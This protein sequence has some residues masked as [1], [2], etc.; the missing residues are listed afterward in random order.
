MINIFLDSNILYLDP[1]MDKGNNKLLFDK[2]NEVG[3]SIFICDVVYKET[4]NNYRKQLNDINNEFLKINKKI[5]N[6]NIE[7]TI[8]GFIDIENQINKIDNKL[9]EYIKNNKLIKLETSNDILPEV[10]DRA[11]NRKKPFKEG[12]QEFRDCVIWLTYAKKVEEDGLDNCFFIT[13]NVSDFC[14]KKQVLHEDLLEDTK[15]FKFHSDPYNFL[16][17]E[18]ELIS[19]LKNSK[20]LEK[21]NSYRINKDKFKDKLVYDDI[22][23]NIKEYLVSIPKTSINKYFYPIYLDYIELKDLD[24][25]CIIQNSN[26]LDA[27]KK[28]IT[29]FGDIKFK[30]FVNLM[31]CD[32]EEDFFVGETY[33]TL[34]TSYSAKFEFED[35][36]DDKLDGNIIEIEFQNIEIES[37]DE[38]IFIEYYLE[39]ESDA[40][41]EMMDALENY[42][43]H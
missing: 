21:I 32:N 40:R 6:L 18:T 22:Y 2:I 13:K 1:L 34:K 9:Q 3:G 7:Q 10:I 14:N 5:K 28:Y 19:M 37:I 25:D 38:E 11:I 26:I 27:N 29:E 30:V 4:I 20:N 31:I 8:V 35:M 42:H 33:V 16:K 12:K 36:E 39:L 43:R 17:Y 24:I 15:K 23:M 41:A